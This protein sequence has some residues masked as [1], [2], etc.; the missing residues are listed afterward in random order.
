M[1]LFDG[2]R[3]FASRETLAAAGGGGG[4]GSGL[5]TSSG[6]LSNTLKTLLMSPS[7]RVRSATA[8]L[9]TSL[10]SDGRFSGEPAAA[11]DESVGMC[12]ASNGGRGGGD[13]D[14]GGGGRKADG[15]FFREV[16]IAAGA[17]GNG[18]KRACLI[19][20]SCA[21]LTRLRGRLPMYRTCLSGRVLHDRPPS[22]AT[23][24]RR[25]PVCAR[26]ASQCRIG[27]NGKL[28]CVLGRRHLKCTKE[29]SPNQTSGC[30]VL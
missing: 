15:L 17:T 10:C 8:R 29:T 13:G 5:P 21:F 24:K 25:P 23:A 2:A 1:A 26:L 27:S 9:V 30:G 12:G 6:G 19:R 14:G 20:E 16:L 11:A 28:V 18:N 4:G 22:Q 7:Y 3:E